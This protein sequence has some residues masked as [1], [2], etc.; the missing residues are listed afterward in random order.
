MF[1]TLAGSLLAVLGLL[2]GLVLVGSPL[3]LGPAAPGFVIWLL[4]PLFTAIGFV[5]LVMGSKSGAAGIGATRGVAGALL[6]LALVAALALF[7]RAAGMG[8]AQGGSLALWYVLVLAGAAGGFGTAAVSRR[9]D[10]DA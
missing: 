10:P 2:S 4:F 3:G 8:A 5:L 6:L 7:A 9:A 1:L